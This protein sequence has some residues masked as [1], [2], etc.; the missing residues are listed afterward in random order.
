MSTMRTDGRARAC[1]AY[2]NRLCVFSCTPSVA[3]FRRFTQILTKSETF[4]IFDASF[5]YAIPALCRRQHCEQRRKLWFVCFNEIEKCDQNHRAISTKFD[6]K[7]ISWAMR[8]S[9]L[10]YS[11]WKFDIPS[12]VALRSQNWRHWSHAHAFMANGIPQIPREMN[13]VNDRN[14]LLFGLWPYFLCEFTRCAPA[15][16]DLWVRLRYT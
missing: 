6:S 3:F 7:S 1:L 12:T 15:V 4:S 13:D 11:I 14:D 5:L 2:N 16:S 9:F 8:A 10:R